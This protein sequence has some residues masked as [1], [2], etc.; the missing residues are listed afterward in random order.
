[1]SYEDQKD[2]FCAA[3]QAV[4]TGVVMRTGDEAKL[5]EPSSVVDYARRVVR[6]AYN[7]N[8]E[9]K[10]MDFTGVAETKLK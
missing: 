1:M 9:A 4:V 10:T 6:A 8:P 7:N 3:V 2:V 5:P